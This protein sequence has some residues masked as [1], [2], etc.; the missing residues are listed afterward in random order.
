MLKLLFCS[1]MCEKQQEPGG[2]GRTPAAVLPVAGSIASVLAEDLI[3]DPSATLRLQRQG[4]M[5]RPKA[6]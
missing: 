5:L 4:G 6:D 2:I 1:P 3:E